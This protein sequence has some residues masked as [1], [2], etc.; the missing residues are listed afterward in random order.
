[1]RKYLIIFTSLL[2]LLN[3]N[4][5]EAQCYKLLTTKGFEKLD[6]SSF[7]FDGSINTISIKQGETFTVTKS[8]FKGKKYKIVVV[9]DDFEKLNFIVIN[10][11]N[12]TLFDNSEKNSSN[13][14][15]Y[16]CDKNQSIEITVEAPKDKNKAE[17]SCIA[18]LLGLST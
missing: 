7:I 6:T 9:S 5:S 14:W 10:N 12:V 16:V 13:T 11:E 18:V 15:E 4:I 17:N 2:F 1:M 3:I 8:L